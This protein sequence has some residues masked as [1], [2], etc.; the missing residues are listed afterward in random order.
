MIMAR[1]EIAFRAPLRAGAELEIGVR[2]SAVGTKSFE[3]DYE[4]RSGAT[5][6]AEAKTVIVSFDYENGR[7]VDLPRSWREAL[8]A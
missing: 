3:L 6:A 2:P 1:V 5:V 7:S 4:V 8:A